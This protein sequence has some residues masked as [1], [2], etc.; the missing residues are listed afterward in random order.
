M[1]IQP[2]HTLTGRQYGAMPNTHVFDSQT[3]YNR[4]LKG[5]WPQ[6]QGKVNKDYF[7]FVRENYQDDPHKSI[8]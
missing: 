3:K 6:R 5:I 8:E 1:Q 4:K 7:E 2:E